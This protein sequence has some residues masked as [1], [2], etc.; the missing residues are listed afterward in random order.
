MGGARRLLR[1][2]YNPVN[3]IRKYPNLQWG[4][5]GGKR[6]KMCTTC[7]KTQHKIV[8]PRTIKVEKKTAA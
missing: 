2:H 6:V 8:R 7:I 4:T 5:V 3:W 1:A